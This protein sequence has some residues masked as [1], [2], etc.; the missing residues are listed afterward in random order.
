MV[1]LDADA[2][3]GLNP[4]KF[5]RLAFSVLHFTGM[6]RRQLVELKWEHVLFGRSALLLAAEGSKSR[7]ELHVPVPAWVVQ[8]LRA[9][10]AEIAGTLGR[11]PLDSEQ[12]FFLPAAA[13]KVKAG[14]LTV[15]HVSRAF[16]SL[17]VQLSYVVSA[18]RVRHT[19]A[20]VMLERSGNIKAVS[21]IL[22][23]S[24]INLTARTYVH[25]RL[26]A[27]RRVQHSLPGYKVNEA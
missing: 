24:D 12:V 6:R 17:S 4:T 2:V 14:G 22:G 25:P 8:G 20:T 27:L 16:A 9:L 11:S 19:S 5:W 18:H 26:G 1:L 21:D 23:H 13:P 10:R 3:V 7:R 15:G